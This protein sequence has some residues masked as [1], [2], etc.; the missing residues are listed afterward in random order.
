MTETSSA[1]SGNIPIR[2]PHHASYNE[3]IYWGEQDRSGA[4]GVM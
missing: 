2:F 4:I 1:V 3:N